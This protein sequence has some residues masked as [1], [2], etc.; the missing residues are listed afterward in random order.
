[1]PRKLP[2]YVRSKTAKGKTYLYFDTGSVTDGGKVILKR[3]PGLRDPTFGRAL[4][5]AQTARDRRDA[6]PHVLT[7]AALASL[8][9]KS[10]EFA[11]LALASQVNYGTYLKVAR[12]RLGIAPADDVTPRTFGSS[13]TRWRNGPARPTCSFAR[14]AHCIHGEG[15]AAMSKQPRQRR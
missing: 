5:A 11:R 10:Q 1:M 4:A 3:L 8:Y 7:V 12:E 15:S 9:E 13:A 6:T 14:S 2:K